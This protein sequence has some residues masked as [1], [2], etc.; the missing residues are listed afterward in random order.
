MVDPAL[1]VDPKASVN[2]W[3]LLFALGISCILAATF[4]IWTFSPTGND[5]MGAGPTADRRSVE[6]AVLFET[7]PRTLQARNLAEE[8]RDM[9][10][11]ATQPARLTAA[12]ILFEAVIE[13][14]PTYFGGYAGAAHATA[15][16]RGLAPLGP[17]RDKVL[18]SSRA[19]A[20][21]ALELGPSE[22]WS[23]S[24]VALLKLFTR[25]FDEALASSLRAV[26]LEPSDLYVLEFD[27]IIAFFAG[28]FVRARASADPEIHGNRTGTRFPWRNVYGNASFYLNEYDRSVAFLL[29]AAA[30]GEPVS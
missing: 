11:P 26:E 23:H 22:A 24:A 15:F 7:S 6:R 21:M 17:Q 3:P 13:L 5:R 30:K 4:L 29:E 10:F 8:A 12:R 9:F 28:D 27:A 25:E 14:D 16:F 19:Y 2:R 20:A 18:S 1:S